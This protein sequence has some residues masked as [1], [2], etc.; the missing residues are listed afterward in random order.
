MP[1]LLF[2]N[3][4]RILVY[5]TVMGYQFDHNKSYNS[6]LDEVL[7]ASTIVDD[8]APPINNIDDANRHE[9]G[10][11]TITGTNPPPFPQVTEADLQ[12]PNEE[13]KISL[14]DDDDDHPNDEDYTDDTPTNLAN[15]LNQEHTITAVLGLA[16]MANAMATQEE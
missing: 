4:A 2:A 15:T 5:Y 14:S 10:Q 7:G 8:D 3:Q 9:C 6:A 1:T 11:H 16:N 13:G 12:F